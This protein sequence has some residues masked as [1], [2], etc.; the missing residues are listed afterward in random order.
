MFFF[1]ET[2]KPE[3]VS[4]PQPSPT[5]G[6]GRLRP[7]LRDF[8]ECGGREEDEA[9]GDGRKNPLQ[10]RLFFFAPKRKLIKKP[11]PVVFFFAVQ[12]VSFRKG[13]D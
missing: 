11:T 10:K 9:P 3:R 6:A 7:S 2:S 4:F 12:T 5:T 8:A 13:M 1:K